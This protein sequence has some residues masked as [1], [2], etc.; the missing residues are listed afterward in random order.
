LLEVDKH[1]GNN[2]LRGSNS[3][4]NTAANLC[5]KGDVNAT[6]TFTVG[7]CKEV[8]VEISG[9]STQTDTS[10]ALISLF[11]HLQF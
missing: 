6:N 1:T 2:N 11:L 5:S 3:I 7:G 4:L 9:L 8:V 10:L